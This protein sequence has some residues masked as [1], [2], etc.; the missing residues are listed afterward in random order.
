MKN[1]ESGPE[2]WHIT[3]P[4][5]RDK[6]FSLNGKRKDFTIFLNDLFQ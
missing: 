2:H 5:S 1:H 3:F 6:D 4:E